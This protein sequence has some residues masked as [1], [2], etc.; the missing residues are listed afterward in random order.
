MDLIETISNLPGIGPYLPY[1]MAIISICSAIA[2]ILSPSNGFA[3][4]IVNY[5][6][7]NVGHATN[8]T[9]PKR[10]RKLK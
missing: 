3:Y 4:R 5:L 1:I 9:D 6:A 2:P 10:K 8:A 7:L